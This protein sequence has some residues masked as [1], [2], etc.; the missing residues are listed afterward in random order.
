MTMLRAAIDSLRSF[1]SKARARSLKVI[2]ASGP[3]NMLGLAGFVVLDLTVAEQWGRLA[4][5]GFAGVVL[6]WVSFVLA[7]G[8]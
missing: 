8:R 7:G 2:E 6:V 4:G 1:P 5:Q 3:S